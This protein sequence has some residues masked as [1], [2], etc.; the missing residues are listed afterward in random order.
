MTPRLD[1]YGEESVL[2]TFG[3]RIDEGLNRRVHGLADAIRRERSLGA[4]WGE[5]VPAY[6]SLLAPFDAERLELAAALEALGRLA[7]EEDAVCALGRDPAAA[8]I[9]EQPLELPVRYGGADGPDL[10]AVAGRLGLAPSGIVRLHSETTYRVYLLGF[11]PGFGYL[12]V[13]PEELVLPR[14][15]EPRPRVPAGSVGIAGRQTCVYPAS[16]PGGWHLIGRTEVRLWDPGQPR[17]ALLRPGMI[18]RFRPT[19]A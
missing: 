16:T 17:P 12:G 9:R 7:A 8:Q 13:L 3:D 19:G 18:V 10:D 2:I 1:P 14:R 6:A 15:A 11:S 5:P 4:P